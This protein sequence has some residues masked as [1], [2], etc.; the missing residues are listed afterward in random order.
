MSLGEGTRL[1]IVW[2]FVKRNNIILTCM[3]S[4]VRAH[5]EHQRH[6]KLRKGCWMVRIR[7]LV[8]FT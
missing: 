4:R 1:Q 7:L 5:L 3:Q 2:S 6:A 8:L